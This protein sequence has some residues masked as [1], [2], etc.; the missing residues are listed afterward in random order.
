MINDL[1]EIEPIFINVMSFDAN[2]QPQRSQ[3]DSDIWIQL[4]E[5][6][7]AIEIDSWQEG[8]FSYSFL[9]LGNRINVQTNY[10]LKW[11]YYDRSF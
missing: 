9:S 8:N 6:L 10:F 3:I 11:N 4:L 5:E 2:K 7:N 1:I